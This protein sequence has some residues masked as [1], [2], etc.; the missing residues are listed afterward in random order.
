MEFLFDLPALGD[1]DD[2]A[3][4]LHHAAGGVANGKTRSQAVNRLIILPQEDDFAILHRAFAVQF[5]HKSIPHGR[6][7]IQV[8]EAA[9][10]EL[11][12]GC[13]TQHIDQGRIRVEDFAVGSREEYSFAKRLKKFGESN[14]GIMLRSDVP[15]PAADGGDP[16]P[17]HSRLQPTSKVAKLFFSFQPHR[18][19]SG[20]GALAN[21]MTK[22]AA[23][24]L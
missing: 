8:T 9:G 23:S 17:V 12:L 20:P 22:G 3:L 5:P 15:R 6:I 11:F 13:V 14:F 16:L 19:D 21:E 10:L 18:Y 7:L 24:L 2:C 4:C 1:I